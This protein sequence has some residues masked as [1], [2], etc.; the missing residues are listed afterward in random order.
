ME[1]ID[2]ELQPL[3]E[4]KTQFKTQ[5][6]ALKD[7]IHKTA[8]LEAISAA[9]QDDLERGKKAEKSL[10][11]TEAKLHA[12][13]AK[14]DALEGKKQA[15]IELKD[16]ESLKVQSLSEQLPLLYQAH[17]NAALGIL[18]ERYAEQAEAFTETLTTILAIQSINEIQ[19]FYTGSEF[20]IPSLNNKHHEPEVQ[21]HFD[22]IEK[23]LHADRLGHINRDITLSSRYVAAKVKAKIEE[24][25]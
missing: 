13:K 23:I 24:I 22:R 10:I 4:D 5:I 19:I 15:V 2:S 1:Q 14:L 7:I 3:I 16:A 8:G 17:Y 21:K 12:L 20:V 18:V 25:L 6:G 9:T 11:D